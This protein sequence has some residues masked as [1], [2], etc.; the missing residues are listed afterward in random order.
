MNRAAGLLLALATLTASTA[1]QAANAALLIELPD[2]VLPS[3]VSSDLTVVGGL[4]EG[5][6]FHWMPTSG[7]VFIG[8]RQALSTSRDGDTIV[9]EALDASRLQQ[10]AIWQRGTEWRLLGSIVPNARP[11]DADLSVAIQVSG[12]G[13]VVVGLGWD[14]CSTARAFRWEESTGMVNLGSTVAGRG[15]RADAVSGDGTV[16]V[17][18]QDLTS[19]FRQGARWVGG[20]QTLFTGPLG[21]VG[22][23]FDTN[24]DGSLV[25]GQVCRPGDPL[26]Q[27]GWVW[28]QRDGL[29][30]LPVPR[31]RLLSRE[32]DFLGRAR[33]TSDDGRVVGGAQAFGLES[34]AVLWLDRQP[35]Y[36]KD[37]LREHGVPNAFEGWVNTGTITDISRD[38]RVLVGW[39]AGP[40][41]FKGYV[42]ILDW[43]GG[44]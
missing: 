41:D 21:I 23:A 10:A 13:K 19:G 14:T 35:F 36:L 20:Q 5:G 39:G 31:L 27:S 17:G 37:Y 44:E 8:G 26:D 16:V 18:F 11:C 24:G 42:V 2:R 33:A 6:G 40:R 9:G 3:G 34:D 30:C 32:G 28:T 15:S 22:Q 12:N 29:Q 1:T 4:G 43:E 25:V 38:G 7:V